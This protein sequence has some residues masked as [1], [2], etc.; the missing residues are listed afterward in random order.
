MDTSS[1]SLSKHWGIRFFSIWSGQAFSLVG[2]GLV[3]FALVWYL[4]R[5]TGSAT[6]LATATLVAMLPQITL[7]PVAGAMV[8]RFNRRMVMIVAD[9]AIALGT[10][11]LVYLFASDLIQI[12]HIYTILM[13]RSLGQ[14]FHYPAMQASTTLMV[15][16]NQLTRISGLNQT[17]MGI[18][19]IVA[20]PSGALL[21]EVLPIQGVLFIDVGTALMAILPLLFIPIPQPERFGPQ[22]QE[23]DTPPAGLFEDVRAGFRYVI[24]WPGL[25]GILILATVINFLL[26][27]TNALIPLL[28]TKHFGLG[29]MAFGLM[30]SAWG[31]GVILGGVILSA[32]GGFQRKV[33]T[34]ML[35]VIGIGLG[36]T[37]VGLHIYTGSPWPAWPSAGS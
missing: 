1:K 31:L 9:G 17:L 15:P 22:S 29:A 7:G 35:G 34:S 3:Q 18:I 13:L 37:I 25:L 11:L 5:Q 36:I 21:L 4:T 12:W 33:V 28:I 19:N 2:S 24:G 26:T 20:P 23:G 30:D 10:L 32:W 6:V 14:A 16:E 27:P 8:D